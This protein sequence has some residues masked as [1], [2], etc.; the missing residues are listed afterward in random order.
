MCREDFE[1]RRPSARALHQVAPK[2][3]TPRRYTPV[4]SRSIS[5]NSFLT[6]DPAPPSG[7]DDRPE[8]FSPPGDS[9]QQER[10]EDPLGRTTTFSHAG[11]EVVEG[12]PRGVGSDRTLRPTVARG[13]AVKVATTVRVRSDCSGDGVNT[14]RLRRRS[15]RGRIRLTTDRAGSVGNGATASCRFWRSPCT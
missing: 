7:H 13:W 9:P 8:A 2:V 12:D 6:A 15:L 1:K 10:G 14:R 4:D 3:G 5:C 11:G